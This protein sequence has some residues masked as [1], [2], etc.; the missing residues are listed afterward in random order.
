LTVL[1]ALRWRAAPALAV[2]GAVVA[3]GAAVV[4]VAPDEVRI[5]VGSS[6][7]LDD[8]T[9]GRYELIEG[10][11]G[12]FADKPLEGWGA[13]AFAREFRRQE[14]TSAERAT[15]AS[16][17]IPVTVAAEQ[18]IAGLLLYLAL[19]LAAL[20]RLFRG[21]RQ[22]IARAAVAAVF[23]AL[24]FHTLLYAAFLEDPLTWALLGAGLALAR[25][26]PE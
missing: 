24:V 21:A 19:V 6:E 7:S 4:I 26:R 1:A 20:M 9:S 18:G 16:H 8:A 5:D 2:L 23:A 17:T 11:V 15:S 22:S 14:R 25:V 3:V 12:L 10:G 13:G